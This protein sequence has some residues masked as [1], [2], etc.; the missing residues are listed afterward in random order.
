MQWESSFLPWWCN[1]FV[2]PGASHL[3][4]LTLTRLVLRDEGTA[5][6][7]LDELALRKD[8][9]V[10]Y[11][12]ALEKAKVFLAGKDRE[13]F[14]YNLL[15]VSGK[16]RVISAEK[17]FTSCPVCLHIRQ[18]SA[19]LIGISSCAFGILHVSLTDMSVWLWHIAYS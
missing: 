12:V 10:S 6:L 9:D 18:I 16:P 7:N 5:D 19:S 14:A 17:F 11:A 1:A 3:F 2:C 13:I 8:K 4:Y 15:N